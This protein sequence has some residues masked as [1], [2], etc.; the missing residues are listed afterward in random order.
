MFNM[1]A[2]TSS[3]EM[4]NCQVTLGQKG[5]NLNIDVRG[6]CSFCAQAS[7]LAGFYQRT[8]TP[9]DLTLL[10]SS[11]AAQATGPWLG[12]KRSKDH[13][14]GIEVSL[15]DGT[16]CRLSIDKMSLDG[17]SKCNLKTE[18]NF[19]DYK[20]VQGLT[21]QGCR[22]KLRKDYQ[23][24]HVETMSENCNFC[25]GGLTIAGLYHAQQVKKVAPSQQ[26]AVENVKEG[27]FKA[28][29]RKTKAFFKK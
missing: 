21:S 4:G 23:G 12:I 6:I 11:K 13:A 8:R 28:L 9:P 5:Q 15:C 29:W 14:G 20:K 27:N 18:F 25:E 1:A 26:S 19:Y 3:V 2:D 17:T 16:E 22:L 7:S 10:T 24:I